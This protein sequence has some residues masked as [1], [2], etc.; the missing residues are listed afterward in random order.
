MPALNQLLIL[1]TLINAIFRFLLTER[2]WVFAVIDS[3][4]IHI[5]YDLVVF[6]HKD[7][8]TGERLSEKFR[9]R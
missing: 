1:R 9:L 3:H 5:K 4:F 2:E 7:F 8:I 6:Y